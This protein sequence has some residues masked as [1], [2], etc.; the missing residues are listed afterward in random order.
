MCLFSLALVDLL[1]LTLLFV[2]YAERIVSQFGSGQRYGPL[3]RYM[4]NHNL[5]G[6]YGLRY[7]PAVLAALIATERCVCVLFPLRA[8][9]CVPTKVLAAAIAVSVSA[10]VVLRF[11]VTAQYRVTCF[12]ETRSQRQSWQVYVTDYHFRNKAMLSALNGVFYGF[13]LSVGCPV[14]VLVTTVLTAVRLQQV[15]KWR[16]RASSCNNVSSSAKEVGVTKMLMALSAEFFVLSIPIIVLR[17][18]PLFQPQFSAGGRYANAFRVMLGVAELCTY[19]SSSVNFFV[20]YVTGT[21]YRDTLRALLGWR[22]APKTPGSAS[23]GKAVSVVTA[24][25]FSSAAQTGV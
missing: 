23:G 5:I 15:V 12:Y 2:F 3:Y 1:Y 13:V 25:S 20:Y 11:L 10:L 9:R 17:V 21:K 14:V 6:L 4:M 8:Q 16:S 24:A 22:P 18:S 19:T 7:G